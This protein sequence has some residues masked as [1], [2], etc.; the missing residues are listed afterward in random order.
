MEIYRELGTEDADKVFK[1]RIM[2]E[3]DERLQ[4]TINH[5]IANAVGIATGHI[6]DQFQL[7][8][9]KVGKTIDEKIE[10]AVSQYMYKEAHMD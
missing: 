7:F 4:I 2:K 8:V 10:R 1:D 3:F 6:E 5:I 9:K